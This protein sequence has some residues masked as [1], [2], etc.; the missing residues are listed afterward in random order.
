MN[1]TN[2]FGLLLTKRYGP[3]F[4]TQFLGAFNDNLFKN[5][6]LIIIAFQA[7]SLWGM[8]P[9][10]LINACAAIFI[11][12][13]FLFSATAGQLAEKYEKARYM[14]AIKIFEIIIACIA[15]L[16]FY[17]SSIEML[18]LVLF[19]LGT[20][21]AFFGPAKYSILPQHLPLR[22]LTAGNA[23]LS[24]GT[25]LAILLG[26]IAGGLLAGGQQLG[27]VL[28]CVSLLIV[29]VIGWLSSRRIPHAK[30]TAAKLNINWE[31]FSAT[32]ANLRY[33]RENRTVF[34][35]ILSYAWF[36]LYGAVLLAQVPA[37][38]HSIIGGDERVATLLLA[39]I[40]IGVGIG[41]LW[42]NA[43]S[44]RKIEI[45][46]VPLGALGLSLFAFLLWLFSHSLPS[47]TPLGVVAFLSQLLGWQILVCVLLIGI[48]SGFYAVPLLAFIQH[49]SHPEHRSRIMSANNILNA[50]FMVV[51]AVVAMLLLSLG[52]TIPQLFLFLAIVN[53]IFTTSIFFLAS[54]FLTRFVAWMI[55]H[56]LYRVTCENAD[57]IPAKGPVIFVS[58][59]VSYLDGFVL[60]AC[61]QRYLHYL[62][63]YEIYRKP[64]IHFWLRLARVIP[65]ASSKLAPEVAKRAYQNIQQ[66]LQHGG[67]IGVFPEG[68]LTRDGEIDTFRP[69][70]EKIVRE[71]PVPV[72]PVALC[73][74]WRTFFSYR[75][76]KRMRILPRHPCP[77][78]TIKFGAPIPPEKVTA[79][80][81]QKIISELR[82]EVL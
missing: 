10:I 15:T 79:A 41:A 63:D 7:I 35:S 65:I 78:I 13:F 27:I 38:T 80:G 71:N 53:L 64:I 59:H 42:C 6:L 9:S 58:N 21:S 28:L 46:L 5:A 81:L 24:L 43:L 30:P 47:L 57:H 74:M 45:G 44:G 50:L 23:M 19:L 36:W 82:G 3:F 52:F 67:A 60:M 31:P 37:Y 29:A 18:I 34:L 48:A 1:T 55:T 26:T 51:G 14:Q 2:P 40:S 33:A 61:S 66:V 73:G 76:D 22:E 72:I 11:L 17:F 39:T 70:I 77:K 49:R 68:Q 16:G 75:R 12:P 69:G 54:E 32:Y 4:W 62:V 25:F 20:Q 56:T 8:S